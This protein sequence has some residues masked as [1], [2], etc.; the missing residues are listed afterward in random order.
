MNK[1]DIRGKAYN[2]ALDKLEVDG[3]F[4]FSC[5]YTERHNG[6]KYDITTGCILDTYGN[7]YMA[8]HFPEFVGGK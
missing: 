7:E 4:M 8:K 3:H 5:G 1:K 6:I 2:E